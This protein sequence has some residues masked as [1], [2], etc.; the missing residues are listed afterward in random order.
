MELSD[1]TRRDIDR[2]I[3]TCETRREAIVQA[4]EIVQRRHGHV[5]AEAAGY[6]ANRLKVGRTDVE[7]VLSF[8]PVYYRQPVGKYVIKVCRSLPC[9]RMGAKRVV[10]HLATRLSLEVGCTGDDGR[11]TLLEVECLGL[12]DR[13]PAMMINDE[14]YG[15][16]TPD[17]IDEILDSLKDG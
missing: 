6:V 10:D 5:D 16:L 8:Y 2:L 14:V 15:P 12:C 3:A 17:R 1:A 7:D 4:L 11:F 13:A 9:A